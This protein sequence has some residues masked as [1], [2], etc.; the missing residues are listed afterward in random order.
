MEEHIEIGIRNDWGHEKSFVLKNADRRQHVYVIGKSGTGK[1]TLLRNAIIQDIEAGRGV[2]IIDPHGDLAEELLDYIPSRRAEDVVYFDPADVEHPVGL[3]LVGQVDSG[4][5]HLI[6]SGIVSSLKGIWSESWGPR[7]EY[8]LFATVAAILECENS[9]LLGV[10]RMLTDPRYRLWVVKQV[11]DPV[12][13]SFWDRE[14]ENYDKRF[15]QEAVTPILNKVGQ[16][17]MSP[18]LRNVLAQVRKKVDVRFMMDKGRIF[19][20]NLSKG[21]LGED[22]ANLLGSLLVTQFHL[23]ALSRADQPEKERK[24]FFLYVDEFQSFASDTFASMLSEAR[25]YRLCLTL[26]HQYVRQLRRE[27]ADAVIGNVGSLISFR[28]GYEDAEALRR[29]FGE[30]LLSSQFTGLGNGEICARILEDGKSVEPFLGRTFRPGG[31]R[32][33]RR[34]KIVK[35]SRE[36]YALRRSVVESKIKRWIGNWIGN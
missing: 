16:L 25:K 35:R 21:K 34:R 31:T 24:D 1:T 32:Y 3:N 7:M 2:G 4:R 28:V 17:F 11:K 14:F 23:A 26:S 8:I 33:G 19:I 29:A 12:V 13:R 36:R 5:R 22:K 20:A 27:V 10:S 15:V 9:T 30:D 18:Q 6:A